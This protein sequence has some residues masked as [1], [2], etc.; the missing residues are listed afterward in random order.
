M[1]FAPRVFSLLLLFSASLQSSHQLALNA[2]TTKAPEARAE[3]TAKADDYSQEA[4]V[5][6]QLKTAYRFEKDGTGMH[7]LTFRAKVQNE[8]AVA[9]LGQL[10]FPY[11]SA[12]EK[13]DIDF[14]RVRKPDGSVVA[15]SATDVQDLTAPVSRQAPVYTDVRQKHITVPGLRPGDTLEYHVVWQ[16]QTPLAANNFWLTYDFIKR[17]AI[18]LDE[19]LAVNIPKDSVIK[20]KTE[21]GFDPAITE[22]TGRRVYLWKHSVLKREEEKDDKE[23]WRKRREQLEDPDPPTIQL[24]TFKSWEDVGQWYAALERDRILPDDK[25][26]AKVQELIRDQKTEQQKIETL[27]EF[28][29]KNFRYVSLSLGQGRYQPHAAADVLSNQYGDCKD[30][31]TLLS[32][33]LIAAGLRGN[34]ALMNSERKIDPDVPSPGQFDHVIT[35]ISLGNE[36][37]WADTTAEIAPFQLLMPQLRDKQALMIPASGPARLV[38]TPA[39]PPFVSSELIDVAASVN[40]LG[41]LTGHV[42]LALRGDTE[43]DYRMLFRRTAK[44]DWKRLGSILCASAGLRGADG[45]EIKTS[46]VDALGKPLEVDLDCKANEFLDW[47]SKKTKVALPFPTMELRYLDPDKRNSSKP[48]QLGVPV[49]TTYRLKLTLP[50][51]Y[52]ARV[53]VSVTVNRDYAAYASV[54]KLEKNTLSAERTYHLRQHEIPPARTQD[55]IAFANAARADEAQTVAIETDAV[56]E[57]AAIPD[58]V[59]TDDLIQAANAAYKNNNYPLAETLYKKV[60]DRDPKNVSVRNQLGYALLQQEKTDEA[61]AVFREQTK[62][63]PFDENAYNQL[64]R[65]FWQ[66]QKYAEAEASFRKQI[67]VTPLDKLAHGN[68]GQMLVEWRKYKEAI[69][70]LEQGI[71]LN[72]DDEFEYQLALGRA[73]L[74]LKTNDKAMAAFDRAIKLEPGQRTWND[75][76]YFLAE[77]KVEL[78]RAQQY[79]ESAVTAVETE[80]RNADLDRLT[81]EDLENV[82]A[83]AADWD[84]LGWV[85]FQKGDL[86]RAEKYIN[87]AW[88]LEQHGEV[89]YHLGLIYEKNGK[90]DAAIK[91]Y[92]QAAGSM[93][94]V[95]E[96]AESLERLIGKD[97]AAAMLKKGDEDNRYSRTIFVKAPSVP[98]GATQARFYVSLTPG[99]G[100]AA[101]VADVKFISGDEKLKP[102]RDVLKTGNFGFVFPGQSATKVIRRGTLSCGANGQCSFIMMSPDAVTSVEQ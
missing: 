42:H 79:A 84:T 86:V 12:N 76:A 62:L 60:L 54:Y 52:Q 35:A 75:V 13:L 23:A 50:A 6:E 48:I 56:T 64:G 36:T 94:T 93:R 9:R 68:L 49:D 57:S 20:L 22:E 88:L 38:T 21:K 45:S 24:S 90:Q 96:A 34:A 51:K 1:K 32:S 100:G 2:Q 70:E 97:K 43:M 95:P 7:E 83:V 15:A 53:P 31:H 55:Y 33:M 99:A 87:A 37:L 85:Y 3:S 40:D 91:M 98:A 5:L 17:D 46:D 78:D 41:Q 71:S 16:I 14:V 28:V 77:T 58:S 92:A 29:A 18:V 69:P 61:I 74:N 19:Q 101:Q 67:E 81:T 30:K 66:Q 44:S 4:V 82:A 8:A 11:T 25:I 102:L 39:E 65:V 80:L 72:P 73:Y 89:G 47:S 10:V 59:K 27:Y 26:K 63:N